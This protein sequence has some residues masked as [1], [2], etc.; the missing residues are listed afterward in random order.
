MPSDSLA[1]LWTI[2]NQALLSMEFSRVS[3]WRELPYP[4]PGDLLDL[5][6]EPTSP[7]L[8]VDSLPLS[9]QGSPPEGSGQYKLNSEENRDL[10]QI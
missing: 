10:Q 7:A 1:T 4:L 9:H 8:Q 5:G 3:Y 6:I 2:A